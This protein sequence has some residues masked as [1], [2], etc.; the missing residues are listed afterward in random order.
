MNDNEKVIKAYE[1]L[2]HKARKIA[3]EWPHSIWNRP[4]ADLRYPVSLSISKGKATLEWVEDGDYDA[5]TISHDHT[6]PAEMLDWSDEQF[7]AWVKQEE[8][9]IA[10]KNREENERSRIDA[11]ARERG[12][13]QSLKAKYG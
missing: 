12:L 10:Q 6:F 11:E 8:A 9:A 13:Y 4:D 5:G 7:A 3:C 2:V 1:A